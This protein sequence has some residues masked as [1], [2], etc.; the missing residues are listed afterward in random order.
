MNKPKHLPV[1][2]VS[3]GTLNPRDVIPCFEDALRSLSG[4][5]KELLALAPVPPTHPDAVEYVDAL[6]STLDLFCPAFCY[7]GAHEG[8]AS[9]FGCWPFMDS[10]DHAIE[11]KE[12][13]ALPDL[14]QLPRAY[15]GDVFLTDSQGN[16]TD[17]YRV[18]KGRSYKQWSIDD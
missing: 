10:I 5:T 18:I 6:I 17:H 15:T 2:T 12:A 3:H 11:L 1:G 16:Y 13:L 8:D 7:F 14:T 4:G 9:D